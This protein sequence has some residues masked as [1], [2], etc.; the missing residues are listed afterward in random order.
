LTRLF[1]FAF[2]ELCNILFMSTALIFSGQ[3]AQ[4]VGMGRDLVAASSRARSL[5]DQADSLLQN[6]FS[7]VCFEGPVETL[8]DTSYCQPALFVHGLALLAILQEEKPTFTFQSVAGLSLGEFTAHTAAGSFSFET[9]LRL[10][11][12]RGRLMQE[13]CLQ[14]EGGMLT[15]IGAST[16]QALELAEKSGLEVANYNCPGQVVLS[17]AKSLIPAAIEIG[18]SMGLKRCLSLNVAGAYHSK[19]M[20]P[21]QDALA[22]HLNQAQVTL[23]PI[24]V[25][26]NVTGQALTQAE[27][28]RQTLIAQVTSS[29]RWEQCIQSMIA[30]GTTRLIELGPGK[31]LAG[32]CKRIN[33]DIPCLSAGNLEELKGILHEIS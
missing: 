7:T 33:K 1:A 25:Y 26:S 24:T 13:A 17:G 29:V 27:E 8:T 15:L 10:V 18:K 16:E 32:M 12:A 6:G 14:S 3:G 23:S 31:I 9:G 2:L 30:A 28:I 5:Y 20:K 19:L 4:H 11:A 21:A 22:P